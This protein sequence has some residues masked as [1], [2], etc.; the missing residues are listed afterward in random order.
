VSSAH[1]AITIAEAFDYCRK[2][3]VAGVDLDRFLGIFASG[4][5]CLIDARDVGALG[6]IMD[7]LFIADGAKPFEWIGAEI[8]KIDAAIFPIVF[9]RLSRTARDLG[10]PAIDIT[11]SGHWSG[12]RDLLAREGVHAQFVDFEMTH[13]NCSWGADR[14][15]PRG[16]RW[17]LVTPD[18]EPAYLDLLNRGMGP[19]PGVYVPDDA[20]ALASM[21]T[22]ADGTK[23]LLDEKGKAQAMV[24]CKLAKR[25]LHLICCAP[26]L[27]GRGLGRL[28]LD[29][30]RRMVG[31]GPLHLS[32]VKQNHHAHG[33]YL[34]VGF[35]ETEQ[36]E[37]WRIPIAS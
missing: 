33:F 34:H 28:A 36:V 9:E 27:Q 3:P 16:W 11:L 18:R 13:A 32:V 20:E 2:H 35:V 31:P 12:V 24:R 25:Y 5:H 23:L 30:V 1:S 6:V 14:P 21:R 37:T 10:I 15:L 22:T 4:A 26:E 7:R 19:M 29:E 17:E 8:D